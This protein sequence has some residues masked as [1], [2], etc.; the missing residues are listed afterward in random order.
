[1]KLNCVERRYKC[2][3]KVSDWRLGPPPSRTQHRSPAQHSEPSAALRHLG[4]LSDGDLETRGVRE[5]GD[6]G[7]V[8]DVEEGRER[9]KSA[10]HNCWANFRVSLRETPQ[11]LVLRRSS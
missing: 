3:N 7:T 6:E 2:N 10:V 11:K 4:S 5:P 1:M 9:K 8:D